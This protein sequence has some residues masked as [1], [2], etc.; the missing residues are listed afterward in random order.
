MVKT[1]SEAGEKRKKYVPYWCLVSRV[2][3]F[4]V[5][6]RQCFACCYFLGYGVLRDLTRK[7]WKK[8]SKFGEDSYLRVFNFAC[9]RVQDE[10]STFRWKFVL[11]FVILSP[12]IKYPTFFSFSGQYSPEKCHP[13]HEKRAPCFTIKTRT[14]YS[15]KDPTPSPNS[16]SLP[17]QIGPKV[18][19]AQS[20]PAYS[21]SA[22]SAIGGFSEDLQKVRKTGNEYKSE[23][24]LDW[25]RFKT[26]C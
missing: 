6:A 19:S 15:F 11:Y 10:C 13:P 17:P 9:L 21:L 4:A 23:F 2:L 25:F 16:Y 22:R 3:N 20:A 5:L 24:C 12:V 1:E 8:G 18:V 14:K 7:I 26:Y